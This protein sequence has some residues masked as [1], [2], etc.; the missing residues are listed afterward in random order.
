M[1]KILNGLYI[2][3]LCVSL[4]YPIDIFAKITTVKDNE[5]YVISSDYA[6]TP[7]FI[8]GSTSVEMSNDYKNGNIKEISDNNQNADKLHKASRTTGYNNYWVIYK[9]VGTWNQHTINMKITLEDVI[10][11]EPSIMCEKQD[12]I[13][14]TDSINIKFLDSSIGIKVDYACKSAGVM[15]LFKVE[16]F[17][18]DTEESLNN[19]KTT[20]T[21]TDIDRD[22]RILLDNNK[23]KETIYTSYAKEH[24][25]LVDDNFNNRYTFFKGNNNWTCTYKG[26][27]GQVGEC[28]GSNDVTTDCYQNNCTGCYKAGMITTLNDGAY[29]IGWAGYYIGFT[30][31]GFLRISDPTPIKHVDKE[32]VKLGDEINYTI[33]QYV[34]NQASTQYYKSWKITDSLNEMLETDINDITITNDSKEIVTDQ[35][36][37]AIENNVLTVSAKEDFLKSDKFY[38]K[39]FFINF[40]SKVKNNTKDIKEIVNDAK[41]NVQYNNG[42]PSD[43]LKSNKVTTTIESEV[44]EV[45]NTAKYTSVIILITGL[46]LIAI[47]VLIILRIKRK[48]ISN[49]S[50]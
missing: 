18:A 47:G 24:L 32:K 27:H 3:I 29:M 31:A 15:G 41:L 30:S 13:S 46:V 40:K 34:P 5:E 6:F 33:E 37:V 44:I 1:K 39:N 50:K 4:I 25:D 28:N 36:N 45:P 10:D 16:F 14:E 23:L 48:K 43:D 8:K 42:T 22:E 26:I 19:I 49:K 17:D 38:N 9:N 7:R 21:Y 11:M 12:G 20:F 2:L 35:F